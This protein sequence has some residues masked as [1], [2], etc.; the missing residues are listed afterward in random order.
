[1]TEHQKK[2]VVLGGG[3]FSHVRNHL[4]V[5]APAFGKTARTLAEKF[6]E[7]DHGMQVIL[8]LT[9]M[10]D[11]SSE[12]VTNVDVE[13]Y[14]HQLVS[15][16]ATK[17]VI[18]NAALC[19]FHGQIGN[20]TSGKH[21]DRI[22]SRDGDKAMILSPTRK[23]IGDIRKQRK[24]IFLVGF[25]TTTG[26][27]EDEQYLAGLNL[28][29]ENSCNLVVAN[30]TVTRRNMI[31]TPEEARYHV[32][33][34]REEILDHLVDMTL[35]RS[36]LTF[37]RSTV[38]AADP[39]PWA[40]DEVPANLREVV[41]FCIEQGAYKAFR[42]ATVG[43][44]ATQVDETTFLTS[45]RKMNFNDMAKVGL[46]RVKTDGPDSVIAYGSKPSVGGQSQRIIFREHPGYKH[47]VHFHCP[48]LEEP[49]DAVPVVSQ[50]EYEC[51]SHE[52]GQN[53]SN[54]LGEF[55]TLKA[56][57]LDNHGPNIVFGDD[58]EPAEVIDFIQANFDLGG[59]TGG[60]VYLNS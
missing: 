45:R 7:A 15:N 41:D 53:T 35:L 58:T 23:V 2:I 38:V 54:G 59:K 18:F 30:D 14:V 31:I 43:H 4:A 16:P 55:G 5:A 9:K 47:I 56:V 60:P 42:G 49:R 21:A 11:S 57:M 44:F 19:D 32:T 33:T 10:A 1:M 13:R 37:T 3:T 28:M 24:D 6:R 27:T 12:L 40:S 8:K 39:V 26:A 22:K 48:L 51:G 36:H 46:V 17:I 50:R 34:D 20:V 29:K 25:K 52:C